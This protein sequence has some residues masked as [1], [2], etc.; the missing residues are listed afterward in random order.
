MD[1]L[2]HPMIKI[3]ASVARFVEKRAVESFRE[4]SQFNR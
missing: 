4:V 2:E 1:L 3:G